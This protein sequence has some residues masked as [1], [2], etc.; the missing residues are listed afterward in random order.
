[1]DKKPSVIPI[2]L[3]ASTGE[4]RLETLTVLEGDIIPTVVSVIMPDRASSVMLPNGHP[5]NVVNARFLHY[6]CMVC[7]HTFNFYFQGDTNANRAD[8]NLNHAIPNRSQ[9]KID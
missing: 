5:A 9:V 4:M 2:I 7:G 1:M 8:A 6:P 3:V